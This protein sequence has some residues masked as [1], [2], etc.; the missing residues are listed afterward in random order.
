[1]TTPPRI[2][3][4]NIGSQ[5]ISLAEFQPLPHRGLMWQDFRLREVV[6]D[7]SAEGLRA[8]EIAA[9]VGEMI[10]ELHLK[11]GRVNL[12]VPGQSLFTRLV[13]LPM[14]EEEKIEQI[15]SFEAQQNVPFPIDEVV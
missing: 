15:I 4:L 13:K 10:A 7:P 8:A 2:I 14:M 11:P 6:A 5:T 3:T 1:M 12:A 9:A